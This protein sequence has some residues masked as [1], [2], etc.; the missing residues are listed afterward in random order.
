MSEFGIEVGEVR[1]DFPR[2]MRR[3]KEVQAH[4]GEHDDPAR[5]AA[6]GIEVIFG[7]GRFEGPD[8][9]EVGGR[10]I[11]ARRFLLATGS[12]PLV[13]EVAGLPEVPFLTNETVFDLEAQP[14]RMAVL[15]G[16]P[17]G[18]ELA[19]AFHHLGT[20][21][22]VLEM[23]PKLLPRLDPEMAG[24]LRGALEESGLRLHFEVK[25]SKVEKRGDE[26]VIEAET[27]G[28]T[29][30]FFCDALLVA[31]GRKANVEGLGLADAGVEY[32]PR[33]VRTDDRLRTSN[34]GIYAVGDVRG[35]YQFTHV[36]EYEA[37]IALRN[38]LFSEPFG[39]PVPFLKKKASYHAV[40][41]AIYTSPEA[42]HVGMTEAEA[43]EA[44]GE[45]HVLRFPMD[46]VD[47][48][49]LEGEASG[50][51][52]VVCDSRGRVLGAD[53]VCPAAGEILPEFAL[54]VRKRLHVKE[55][56]ETIH[57][58]PT[59]AEVNKRA[60]GRYY[61][62]KLFTP[63]FRKKMQRL[64]GLG[65]SL[66]VTDPKGPKGPGDDEKKF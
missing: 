46:R 44:L 48:A 41:W 47:R 42:A 21:V 12:S 5:F 19:Q 28:G 24:V 56:V 17:I 13:P 61:A 7:E 66:E 51:C 65:G 11:R 57:V 37:G 45:I 40:P 9:F 14:R 6:M 10:R 23:M 16:G 29:R 52:K 32:T 50:F 59:L 54:A 31:V 4:I 1:V 58:Y 63:A 55:V 2:V 60:A 43:R 15:G 64:F 3:M 33:G 36:A 62:Q 49:I 38:M 30:P 25:V 26:I 53:L 20:E 39:I 8:L 22:E 34:P 35:A 27:P 18:L